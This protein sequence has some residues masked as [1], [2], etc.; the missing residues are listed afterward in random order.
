MMKQMKQTLLTNFNPEPWKWAS[1]LGVPIM[2]KERALQ[3]AQSMISVPIAVGMRIFEVESYEVMESEQDAR[4]GSIFV[5]C[6]TDV[7]FVEDC[8][9]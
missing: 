4:C 5:N 2:T 9:Q 1:P 6:E 8:P 7:T 3:Y